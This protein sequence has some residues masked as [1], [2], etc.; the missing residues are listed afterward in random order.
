[1][2]P[3]P[4]RVL[5]V[6]VDLAEI[7]QVQGVQVDQLKAFQVQAF[8]EVRLVATQVQEQQAVE[9]HQK[10]NSH[11]VD[12]LSQIENIYRLTVGNSMTSNE[13]EL[14]RCIYM[15]ISS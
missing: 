13:L 6:Q 2:A 8:L 14:P 4:T 10:Q 9:Y 11:L 5:V 1:V 15:Y 12:R 3:D 7:S